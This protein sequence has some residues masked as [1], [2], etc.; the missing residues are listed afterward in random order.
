ML[1]LG[2]LVATFVGFLVVSVTDVSNARVS[3]R[4]KARQQ[5]RLRLAQEAQRW[6]RVYEALNAPGR[7]PNA[8][9]ICMGL[10]DEHFESARVPS[11]GVNGALSRKAS[12][13]SPVGGVTPDPRA[14]FDWLFE[15][16][17]TTSVR[18]EERVIQVRSLLQGLR[19][20][21]ELN[22]FEDP[23]SGEVIWMGPEFPKY[24]VARKKGDPRERLSAQGLRTW[25]KIAEATQADSA[26]APAGK[27]DSLDATLDL[28]LDLVY[29]HAER[30]LFLSDDFSE[31]LELIVKVQSH[32]NARE[33]DSA[34]TRVKEAMKVLT[35]VDLQKI[36]EISD[37]TG[38]SFQ[39]SQVAA[40]NGMRI[41][42]LKW[43]DQLPASGEA[44]SKVLASL[45]QN[46]FKVLNGSGELDGIAL[47]LL[48][49]RIYEFAYPAALEQQLGDLTS[50]GVYPRIRFLEIIHAID[51][52]KRAEEENKP[53]NR[54]GRRPPDEEHLKNLIVEMKT[55]VARLIEEMTEARHSER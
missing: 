37:M 41:D 26:I 36:R 34:R 11:N 44:V 19:V 10:F 12:D 53:E 49:T 5:Q 45:F 13:V 28:F 6:E 7:T 22:Q 40:K 33:L 39:Q 32:I 21:E 14:E 50:F 4:R 46:G 42:V 31:A 51:A 25:I 30:N 47:H 3:A 52:V 23:M 18:D 1:N 2:I 54:K 16:N 24:L 35:D 55:S 20:I 29:L 8:P 15:S 17:G 43:P 9:G 48:A 27:P 38:T